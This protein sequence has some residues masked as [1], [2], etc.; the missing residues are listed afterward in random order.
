MNLSLSEDQ[1][2]LRDSFSRLFAQ[3]ATPERVR[4]AESSG[5]DAE[6]WTKLIDLGVPAM[7]VPTSRGG[8]GCSLL[9]ACILAAEMG[10][11]V[12]PV[13]LI[14][15]L[16]ASR[17]LAESAN[18]E[19]CRWLDRQLQG[20]SVISFA[21]HP[22]TADYTQLVPAGAIA[23]A[24]ICIREDQL[25]L[26]PGASIDRERATDLGSGA[27]SRW[28]LTGGAEAVVV[29]DSGMSAS[30]RFSAAVE[31]WKL[32]TASAMVAM[33][34]QALK[35]AAEYSVE[36]KAFGQAIG[37]YQG[38]A[39]PMAD[40]ATELEGAR[41]LTLKANSALAQQVDEAGAL[42]SMA[43]WWV[44]TACTRAVARALH[45][46]G[47]YGLSMEYPVQL[48]HRRAKA[49]PLLLGD[50]ADALEE[51]ATRLWGCREE[52]A[53][54]P[55]GEVSLDFSYGGPAEAFAEKARDFF[56][57]N[58]TDDLRAHAHHSWEGHHPGFQR[59]L[60]EAGLLLPDWPE[61]YGG[62]GRD[63]YEMQAMATVFFEFGWT[64]NAIAVTD[65]VGKAILEFGSDRAREE[66]LPKLTSGDAI[67]CLGF[68]EP[69]CGSDV[70]AAQTRAV[71]DGDQWVINGQKM[72][73]SG[74][75]IADYILLL[76]RTDPDAEK[77]LGLTMFIVPARQEGI[78]IQA[79]HT[80][81]DERTN[82]TYYDDVRVNDAMRIGE[83]N[84]GVG[85]MAK[86][87]SKE[88][89]GSAY[90]LAQ[91]RMVAEAVEWAGTCQR[92]NG[93]PMESSG[94]RS[95]LARAAVHA[96]VADVLCRRHLWNAAERQRDRSAGPMS[97]LFS[98]ERY[99]S[100]SADLLDLM[101]PDSL[102]TG[103]D[104]VFSVELDYRLSTATSIYAGSSEIMRSLIAENALNMPRTRN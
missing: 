5:F 18:P 65:M 97:K 2:V 38:L 29:L 34:Q 95:R 40:S 55:P 94:V 68:S 63:L 100:D 62:Q 6:L 58:L 90:A 69:A 78:E 51:V 24:V 74:A 57:T 37:S 31:E 101:A 80:L 91:K 59:Q 52:I 43:Y 22:V 36:R 35:M 9:D 92:G 88:Q 28:D 44:A 81:A 75:D 19:A 89:D 11:F 83:V 8:V 79:V 99:I 54:P 16:I 87:L 73:T 77:H 93:K 4:A 86:S 84:G 76:T 104:A 103:A 96:E 49:W 13:P 64:R 53:L 56:H 71:A 30:T 72:F 50:P 42:V 27:M 47:G 7:R 39:H 21:L 45:V 26:V 32:L 61:V 98:S 1:A 14:E 82:V 33:G 67:C 20:T 60:A 41:W 102:L 25:V 85:V 66:I 12:A 46:F 48:Y 70:F 23:D 15:T 3:E 17:L 10:R